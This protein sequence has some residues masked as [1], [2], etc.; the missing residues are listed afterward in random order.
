MLN[1]LF[2]VWTK[3]NCTTQIYKENFTS[4]ISA[5]LCYRLICR[6]T[7]EFICLSDSRGKHCSRNAAVLQSFSCDAFCISIPQLRGHQWREWAE[8]REHTLGAAAAVPWTF[9]CCLAI[10]HAGQI[11]DNFHKYDM[12]NAAQHSI[13]ISENTATNN[14]L[15]LALCN[16]TSAII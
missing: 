10:R 13:T 11:N 12:S 2:I 6:Y 1:S 15:S 8:I 5:A 4:G 3:G 7:C 16:T 9:T 14:F